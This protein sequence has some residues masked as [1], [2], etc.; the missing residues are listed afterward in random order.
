MGNL[1]NFQLDL[2]VVVARQKKI[3]RKN[4]SKS[5]KLIS[6]SVATFTA[7]F[8]RQLSPPCYLTFTIAFTSKT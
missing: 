4:S 1:S 2:S 7:F 5:N 6:E 3:G 8:V